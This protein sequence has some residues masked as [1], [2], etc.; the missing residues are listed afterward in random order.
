MDIS[1]KLD[2]YKLNV[3]TCAFIRCGDEILLCEHKDKD[4]YSLP[5]GH[6]KMGEDSK[7]ALMR[8]L[9]EE[10]N[11][12]LCE[13]DLRIVRCIENFFTYKD[14]RVFHEYLFI[15]ELAIDDSIYNGDF[16]NLENDNITMNWVKEDAFIL[17]NVEPGA[18]KG[19]ISNKNIEHII[20]K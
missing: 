15:Y 8:E 4:Y 10:L 2:D 16:K 5:G 14:G 3:R 18:V 19:I 17:L 11:Y 7:T 6:V 12:D 1:I 13:N 20:L 9:K